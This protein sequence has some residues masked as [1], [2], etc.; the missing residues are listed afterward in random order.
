MGKGRAFVLNYGI[1][2]GQWNSV[3]AVPT[4]VV[5]DHMK[6]AG[7]A[8][9]KVLLYL[10]RHAGEPVTLEALAFA[11]GQKTAD[12]Q[13]AVDYWMNCGVLSGGSSELQPSK[14]QTAASTESTAVLPNGSETAGAV[15]VP[16]AASTLPAAEIKNALGQGIGARKKDKI[17]YPF[18]E[19]MTFVAE[20]DQLKHMLTV[21]ESTLGKQ[22]T[23]TEVT[24]F[25]T[26]VKWYGMPC[27][28]VPML[29]Q[30]CKTIGKSNIS[31]IEST[32]IGWADEEIDTFEKAEGKIAALTASRR[33]WNTVRSALEIPERKATE[34]EMKYSDLWMNVQ[35]IDIE[36]VRHAYDKCINK[37]G[38]ISF[39]YMNGII[40]RYFEQGIIDIA[41]ALKLD[42]QNRAEMETK[43]A[44]R[45][46]A[47]A[48]SVTNLAG[49]SSDS[50]RYA[51]TYATED[52]EAIL[53]AEWMSERVG[54]DSDYNYDD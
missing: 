26:L 37:N 30:Y 41:S 5:D 22:L 10:L 12:T 35:H 51:E 2:L 8:Q 27:T 3:F 50:G 16:A 18:D 4:S 52:I 6:L 38:K 40:K 53:D 29:I 13:D 36:L 15:N 54:S 11:V 34:S 28:I 23:H 14:G 31:Y 20:D 48:N 44:A 39:A 46:E 19:C 32:G 33:A 7:A 17:R 42:E 9:L 43:R 49:G 21:V 1:N 24:C 45:K 25:V 47:A